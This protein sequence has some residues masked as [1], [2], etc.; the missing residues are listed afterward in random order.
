MAEKNYPEFRLDSFNLMNF[1]LRY[2][3]FFFITGVAAF[4]ISAAITLTITP[5][6]RSTVILYPASNI[7]GSGS[8]FFGNESS[9]LTFGDE[10][11]TEKILQLLQSEEIS[12]F[13]RDKYDLFNHYEIEDDAKY[14]YTQLGQKMNKYISY[15]KTRYMSVRVDVLDHD[16]E[17]AACMANDIAVMVDSSF[18]RL[19]KDAGR[20]QLTVIDKQYDRQMS[21]VKSYEDSLKIYGVGNIVRYNEELDGGAIRKRESRARLAQYSPDYLRFSANHEMA[22]ED[23]GVIRQRYTEARMAAEEDFPYT[24][25]VNSAR[26]AEKKAFP[27]RSV[28]TI[29]STLATLLFVLV[30]LIFTDGLKR[31]KGKPAN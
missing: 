16:P 15:R 13:L 27:R 26:V 5:L 24:L 23:L 29:I 28:I 6:F 9:V 21:L 4:I 2:R 10:E 14:R 3:N 7:T 18:N 25:V 31:G 1:I 20:K 22:L 8:M 12:D 19:L 17:I 11:G 30:V